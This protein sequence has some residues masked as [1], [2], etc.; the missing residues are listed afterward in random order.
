MMSD[1]EQREL[2]D[3]AA[4]FSSCT[5]EYVG[6]LRA[7]IQGIKEISTS[8]GNKN[9]VKDLSELGSYLADD[10]HNLIDCE[11][12]EFEEIRSRIKEES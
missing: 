2:A 9:V 7:V 12:E 11:R 6:F 3:K 10:F 8:N 1:Q 4:D 5:L